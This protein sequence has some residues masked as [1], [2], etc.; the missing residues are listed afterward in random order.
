MTFDV[1]RPLA[2]EGRACA[3]ADGGCSTCA[4]APDPGVAARRRQ[5]PRAPTSPVL[6]P[7]EGRGRRRG[8]V[9]GHPASSVT[10]QRR[11][12]R[13][14][15]RVAW[16]ELAM[17]LAS[18]TARPRP[19]VDRDVDHPYFHPYK[20]AIRAGTQRMRRQE[21]LDPQ[22]LPG[23]VSTGRTGLGDHPDLR[24][25]QPDPAGGDRQAVV[26]VAGN[27]VG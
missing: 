6:E 22:G 7:D 11:R 19:V 12:R 20:P 3:F 5:A 16:S 14:T 21:A 4:P 25:H 2:L 9:C 26:L 23:R 1:P 17:L 13:A 18:L 10:C 27:P 15:L 8:E 24:G